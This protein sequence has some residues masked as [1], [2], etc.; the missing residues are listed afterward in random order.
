MAKE[1]IITVLFIVGLLQVSDQKF[2]LL[3]LCQVH[4]QTGAKKQHNV[5][6]TETLW[7]AQGG[8]EEV[9]E[10]R[11]LKEIKKITEF[12]TDICGVGPPAISNNNV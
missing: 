11:I 5:R 3:G 1:I 6:G 7:E 10:G 2:L 4:N 8:K 12:S 9:G